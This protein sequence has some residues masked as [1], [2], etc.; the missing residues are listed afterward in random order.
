MRVLVTGGAGN[1]GRRVVG[2]LATHFDVTVYDLVPPPADLPAR[3]LRGDIL[4][5]ASLHWAMRDQEAVVHLAAFPVPGR[6]SDDSVMHVNVL[7]TQRVVEAAAFGSPRRLVMAS[8]DSVY[9]FVFGQGRIRPAY[10]P[11]DE[12]HPVR[13]ADAYGLSK[14]LGEEI[15]RRYTRSHGLETVCLRY[16]W[17]FW[18]ETYAAL[19]AWQRQPGAFRQQMWG[20][21][22]VRDVGSAIL[23][24]L[25]CPGIE[26]ETFLLSARRNFVGQP[27]FDLVREFWGPDV[28]L[29]CP[30]LYEETPDAS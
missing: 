27:T 17:V 21:I 5:S 4:D 20:Y 28:E 19:P 13:P 11:V 9:G 23:A 16:C 2:L 22:D 15:C 24:A 10:V 8:S 1:V 18:D 3:F 30:A 25:Q 6:V 26:H 29:R 14:Y 12:E 7:G